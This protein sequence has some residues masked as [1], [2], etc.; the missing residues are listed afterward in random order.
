[1]SV[2]AFMVYRKTSTLILSVK[3]SVISGEYIVNCYSRV[4]LMAKYHYL[5]KKWPIEL[6]R[7]NSELE[8]QRNPYLMTPIAPLK[9]TK[10]AIRAIT[11]HYLP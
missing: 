1:M 11:P 10:I 9:E 3:D 4:S 8:K 2:T 6:T 5:L 7:R